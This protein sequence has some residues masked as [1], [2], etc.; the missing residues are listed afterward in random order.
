MTTTNSN[1]KMIDIGAD[2][3]LE[4]SE[5]GSGDPL[6]LVCGTTQ[7]Y[8]L[9]TPLLP[10]LAEKYRVIC[11][12]HRGIGA[13]TRGTGPMTVASLAQ[14]LSELLLALDIGQAH[15]LGWSLGSAVA[16]E[17]A[18]AHPEC[19]ASLVLAATWGRTDNFQT[20]MFTG[21]SHPWRTRDRDAAITALGLAYS[22]EF[23]ASENFSQVIAQTAPLFP[24][25]ES[26]M[27]A[28]VE[29]FD[30]DFAHDCIDRLGNIGAP[31]L[32]IAGDQDLL[33]PPSHGRAVADAIDGAR[34]EQFTG[35]GSSHAA[36]LERTDEF[37]ELVLHFLTTTTASRA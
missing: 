31:T 21:L 32:V 14:D 3:Q 30:A 7:D 15:V 5:T 19:V 1:E 34:F 27:A 4:V 33:T 22:P 24:S 17:F 25:S 37:V 8:R 11:Y 36:L 10:V 23:L 28:A 12:N 26:Q 18:L 2:A 29:Q 13:S 9:W 20:S 35:P 6:V 16:Q